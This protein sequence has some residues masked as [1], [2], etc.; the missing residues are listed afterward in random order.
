MKDNLIGTK[1]I[2]QQ[3]PEQWSQAISQA[4]LGRVSGKIWKRFGKGLGRFE[5]GSR[6][7]GDV[8]ER[9][10]RGRERNGLVTREKIEQLWKQRE[11]RRKK[12]SF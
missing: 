9:F 2:V 3:T 6:G 4:K 1:A 8:Q 11:R 10:G 7:S 5:R 12:S